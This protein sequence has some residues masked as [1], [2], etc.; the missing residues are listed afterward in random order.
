MKIVIEKLLV[1]LVTSTE[2][3]VDGREMMS[4]EVDEIGDTT[5][6]EDK[7]GTSGRTPVETSI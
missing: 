4:T 6:E 2:L 5:N 7:E 1:Q 3:L